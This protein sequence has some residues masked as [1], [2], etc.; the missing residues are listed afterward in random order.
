[1]SNLKYKIIW[2]DDEINFDTI[3]PLLNDAERCGFN[4]IGKF[5]T[6]EEGISFLKENLTDVDGAILD[7]RVYA[8]RDSETVSQ[9][10]LRQSLNQIL[11]ISPDLPRVV[12]TGQIDVIEGNNFAAD[13]IGIYNKTSQIDEM[14]EDLAALIDLS[15]IHI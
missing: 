5:T 4:V 7:A 15:L 3:T 11:R 9:Q 1:M 8:D 12:C 14:F 10:A 13:E 6:V 2:I